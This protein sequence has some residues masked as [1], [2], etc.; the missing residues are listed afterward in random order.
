MFLFLLLVLLV[1][2]RFFAT[3]IIRAVLGRGRNSTRDRYDWDLARD[4]YRIVG[5]SAN[6]SDMLMHDCLRR[7]YDQRRRYKYHGWPHH[8]GVIGAWDRLLLHGR[9]LFFD[10]ACATHYF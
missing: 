3:I 10:G 2:L 6:H 8:V 5:I 9:L 1:S 4:W 7:R